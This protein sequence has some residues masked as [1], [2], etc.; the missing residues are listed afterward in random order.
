MMMNMMLLG[1][2][3]MGEERKDAY[4]LMVFFC[5]ILCFFLDHCSLVL[6]V[7]LFIYTMDAYGASRTKC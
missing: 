1:A 4:L 5:T 2:V 6:I 7:V 3:E